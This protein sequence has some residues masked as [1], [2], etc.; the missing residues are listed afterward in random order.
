MNKK[1]TFALSAIM[2]LVLTWC[3]T[4]VDNTSSTNNSSSNVAQ[5]QTVKTEKKAASAYD[6]FS[7]APTAYRQYNGQDL[8][9]LW[10]ETVLYFSQES[11]GTCQKTDADLKSQESLPDGV[12]ILKVDYDTETELNKKYGV[13]TKHTFVL[14]DQNGNKIAKEM[15]LATTTE[16]AEFV[17]NAKSE[18]VPAASTQKA[19]PETADTQKWPAW[20]VVY[21]WQ[22]LTQ[23]AQN[24][25][26][27]FYQ[28]SCGTCQKTDADIKAQASLPNGI[29]ILR[30]DFDTETELN[31]KYGVTTKHT[32][33]LIDADGNEIAKEI[34]LATTADIADFIKSNTSSAAAAVSTPEKDPVV[35]KE[36][37]VETPVVAATSTKWAY[38][39]YAGKIENE[40]V[41]FFSA[42]WCPSCVA[43][44]KNFKSETDLAINADI[45]KVDY[46]ANKD[47]RDKYGV[48]SQHTFVRVDAQGNLIKKMVGWSSSSALTALFN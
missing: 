13:T 22:D 9:K 8:S 48:T 36:T 33:V 18:E 42:S 25:V 20:Y 32:F 47:L 34:G 23:L 3:G 2:L 11:C 16:I 5:E 1:I 43:A 35:A 30:V 21:A 31:K 10:K 38:K 7:T 29:N 41:L 28:A 39:N 19:T 45:L 26:L 14:V 27:Y 24:T 15:G 12:S 40:S 44:D 46:D 4:Q 17:A 6:D 37:A